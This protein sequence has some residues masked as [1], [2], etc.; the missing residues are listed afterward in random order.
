MVIKELPPYDC[1]YKEVFLT[2]KY[3]GM[4]VGSKRY[5]FIYSEAL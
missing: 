2:G 3:K 5:K 1:D 4:P